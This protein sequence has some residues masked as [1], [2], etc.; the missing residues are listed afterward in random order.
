MD[1]GVLRHPLPH[2]ADA[3]VVGRELADL[4]PSSEDRG[5]VTAA[6]RLPVGGDYALH[7]R[8]LGSWVVAVRGVRGERDVDLVGDRHRHDMPI[9]AERVDDVPD[10][11]PPRGDV[12]GLALIFNLPSEVNEFSIEH[13]R[14]MLPAADTGFGQKRRQASV[15][16]HAGRTNRVT[17]RLEPAGQSPIAH[18]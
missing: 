12:S 8:I 4:S 1:G 14:F 2:L 13:P 17:V 16:L 7:Q 3:E 5:G 9:G 11:V 18:Y 15:T 10:V 6:P